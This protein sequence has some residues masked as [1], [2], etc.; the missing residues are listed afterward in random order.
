MKSRNLIGKISLIVIGIVFG[1]ILVSSADLVK[2]S[3]AEN[4]SIGSE[5]SPVENLALSNFNTAFIEVAEKVTPSIVSINVVSSVKEDPHSNLFDF[6]FNFPQFKDK[7]KEF[8]REGGGSGV[9]ISKD[10]YILTNN[11]VVENASKV[12]IHLFDKRELEAE[13]IG[14]DPLTDLAVVKVDADNLPAAYMG[15]SDKLRVG[16]WV[17][18]IGNPLSYLT[19]TVT[20]GIVSA[21]S[22]NI[23]IIKDNYGIE[24][25]IQTDAA[26][27]PGNSG[28]ALVDLNGAVVGINSAIATSGFSATYIGYGFAIPINIA[29]SVAQ[30]LIENGEVSR[31]YIGVSITEVDAATAKAIGLEKP[32]GIMIQNVVEDGSAA[33]EDIIAGDVI[34][35]IDGKAVDKPNQLQSYIATKRAGTEVHLTLFRDGK[36]INRDVVLKARN[37]EK[38]EN[39][40]VVEL[41]KEKKKDS[42]KVQEVNFKELGLTVQDLNDSLLKKY[43]VKNG[44]L[45]KDV[46]QFGKASDQK[47]FPGLLITQIDKKNINSAE[48]FEDIINS[49]R[50]EAVLLKVMDE[51]GNTRF[52]GLEIPNE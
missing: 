49:K 22:R 46:E 8:K 51:N 24:D 43:K 21:T 52:V 36:K 32:M 7:N 10:G 33:S 45:I 40:E 26:I 48:D 34:L 16:E 27:N 41:K 17:M 19:S 42:N 47:L 2:F 3:R 30:D 13:I 38:E 1:A 31:G 14:K 23:G 18:A 12:T 50:G 39:T 20:A 25:F 29:K 9:I 35:E 6:P 4:I 37:N 28:G 44:V 5:S 11:H 15:D